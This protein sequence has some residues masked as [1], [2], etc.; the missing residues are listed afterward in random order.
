MKRLAVSSLPALLRRQT[1]LLTAAATVALC[2]SGCSKKLAQTPASDTPEVSEIPGTFIDERDGKRYKTTVIADQTWMA[3][4]LNYDIGN[5]W[6]YNNDNLYCGKYGRLYDWN[7][8]LSACPAGWRLPSGEDWAELIVAAGGEDEAGRTLKSVSGWYNKNGGGADDY[9]FS[10]LPGGH[11]MPSF[12]N[13]Y[14]FYYAGHHAYLWTATEKNSNNAYNIEF[15]AIIRNRAETDYMD[16]KYGISV[17]CILD[18]GRLRDLLRRP[19]VDKRD[20][21]EELAQLIE[22]DTGRITHSRDSSNYRA[23]K[24]GGA[25]R[26]APPRSKKPQPF[27]PDD[28]DEDLAPIRNDDEDSSNNEEYDYEMI[29]EQRKKIEPRIE[30]LSTY[31]TDSRDGR[32]YRA[33]TIGGRRWMA[34]NLDYLPPTGESRCY[35]NDNSDCVI[36]GRRYDWNTATTACPSGW[37]LPTL[38]EWNDLIRAAGGKRRVRYGDIT[39]L[40]VANKLKA[41]TGWWDDATNDY[42]FSALPGGET[43]MI[44]SG[45]VGEWWTATKSNGGGAAFFEDI[46][47][48]N[49]VDDRL[50]NISNVHTVRCVEDDDGDSATAPLAFAWRKKLLEK[51]RLE[52]MQRKREEAEKRKK[53]EEAKR[54]TM[55]LAKKSAGY[56]TDSR[57]GRKYRAVTISGKRWMAENLNYAAAGSLCYDNDTSNCKKYGRLYNWETAGKACPSGWRLPMRLEW[58]HLGQEV[59]GKWFPHKME[60]TIRWESA[61]K[62][63]KAKSGWNDYGDESGNGTDDYGFSA[64]P[65]GDRYFLNGEFSNAGN[66]GR[67]WTD[68][69]SDSHNAYYRNMEFNNADM[70]EYT[71][72]KSFEFSVRCIQDGK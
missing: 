35:K 67:W 33:V 14:N 21:K 56:F 6:C 5:S 65:G 44:A 26:I 2:L 22:K 47:G 70:D 7:T 48:R 25:K 1:L 50:D 16:K 36:Y 29:A 41:K 9:G 13:R 62:I 69:E 30:R 66:S 3:E 46:G 60:G 59:G 72:L 17:R 19:V 24:T 54:E 51:R 52:E 28:Y 55:L 18:D 23:V 71:T 40:D 68:A 63:L 42:G 34:E 43:A 45:V 27:H 58:D 53:E 15:N 11:S 12:I 39:W 8:A 64:L 32:E 20:L 10:A 4:N 57:D 49:D 31:F 61:G 38:M 37:H